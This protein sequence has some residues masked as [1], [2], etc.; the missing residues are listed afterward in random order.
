M[1]HERLVFCLPST[2]YPTSK[3]VPFNHHNFEF[4]LYDQVY[5]ISRSLPSLDL[6]V[7]VQSLEFLD[8]MGGR[9][10]GSRGSGL[11]QNGLIN[12]CYL[13]NSFTPRNVCYATYVVSI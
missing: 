6:D 5:T 12:P 3:V 4:R 9:N 8:N 13:K 11:E 10:E 7:V 1:L 2:T